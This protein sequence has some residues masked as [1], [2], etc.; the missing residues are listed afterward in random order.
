MGSSDNLLS[1]LVVCKLYLIIYDLRK[2]LIH[3]CPLVE[4]TLLWASM[5][6]NHNWQ[7][8]FSENFPILCL[9]QSAKM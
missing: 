7:T 4:W 3:L 8:T 1:L 9:E 5:T 2:K 6:E